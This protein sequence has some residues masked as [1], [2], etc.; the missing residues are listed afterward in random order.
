MAIF[1][2]SRSISNRTLRSAPGSIG[3]RWRFLQEFTRDVTDGLDQRF[4]GGREF[5]SGTGDDADRSSRG[6]QPQRQDHDAPAFIIVEGDLTRPDRNVVG[7]EQKPTIGQQGQ[8]LDGMRRRL[9]AEIIEGPVDLASQRGLLAR[10]I[11]G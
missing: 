1:A 7:V 9:E 11:Q 4:G 10:Q 6:W 8:R 3:R 5:R 2:A